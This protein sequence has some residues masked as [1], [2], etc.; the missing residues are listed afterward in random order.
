MNPRAISAES[1][2]AGAAQA[3]PQPVDMNLRPK[4]HSEVDAVVS[5]KFEVEEVPYGLLIGAA[6]ALFFSG[7][8]ALLVVSFLTVIR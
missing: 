2:V 7:V 3:S 1:I 6:W 5:A 8:G 4:N